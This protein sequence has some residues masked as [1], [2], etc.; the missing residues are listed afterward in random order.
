MAV[1]AGEHQS[2]GG[3]GSGGGCGRGG[4]GRGRGGGVIEGTKRETPGTEHQNRIQVAN[5]N[6]SVT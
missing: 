6:N 2:G 5:L 1:G 4:G 3:K